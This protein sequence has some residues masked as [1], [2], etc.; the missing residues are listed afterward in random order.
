[1]K[2]T[3]KEIKNLKRIADAMKLKDEEHPRKIWRNMEE[4]NTMLSQAKQRNDIGE[5]RKYLAEYRR[6]YGALKNFETE[7]ENNV[8]IA[9]SII[10]N[11]SRY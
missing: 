5:I 4:I 7:I 6:L 11:Y 8:S 10:K 2:L 1:M 9:E 3:K